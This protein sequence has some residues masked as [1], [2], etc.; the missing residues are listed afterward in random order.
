MKSAGRT[1]GYALRP[2][3]VVATLLWDSNQ[4]SKSF[5][6][7]YDESWAEKL[8]R[9][10]ARNLTI[11]FEFVCFTDRERDFEEPI[12]QRLM[13]NRTP[14]YGDCIEPYRL[15]RPMILVGL[16]TIVTGNCD[17]L[18]EYCFTAERI[19]V[20]LD[21]Y[22]P[23]RVCNGVALVPAGHAHV[24]ERWRGQNDMEWIRRQNPDVLDTLFPGQVLS[25]KCHVKPNGLGGA[26]I[27]YFHGKEKPH[28]IEEGWVDQHWR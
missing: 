25:Y 16:D 4:N 26:R 9:G 7:A 11:P 24:Y 3:L 28:E 18:A 19:A 2:D 17:A 1:G 27:V 6:Q 14:G 5:S 15:N 21:P 23:T 12:T 10:F 22:R 13:T 8:Y 20:P